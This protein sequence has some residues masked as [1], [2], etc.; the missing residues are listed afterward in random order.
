MV[1][2]DTIWWHRTRSTLAQVRACCLKVSRHCLNQLIISEIMWYPISQEMLSISF[3]RKSHKITHSNFLPFLS[4]NNELKLLQ[5][6]KMHLKILSGK[7]QPFCLSLHVLADRF[8][9]KRASNTGSVSMPWYHREL[10][11]QTQNILRV[12]PPWMK[13]KIFLLGVLWK[14]NTNWTIMGLDHWN[15]LLEK[16]IMYLFKLHDSRPIAWPHMNT[17]LIKI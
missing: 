4:R 7:W 17:W 12:L 1:P 14:K 13:Y 3:I 9:S 2:S 16:K 11:N 6:R 8:P 15:L 5:N 10:M